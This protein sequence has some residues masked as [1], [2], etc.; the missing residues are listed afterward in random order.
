MTNCYGS[1]YQTI[2]N[3]QDFYMFCHNALS[4]MSECKITL[5]RIRCKQVKKHIFLYSRDVSLNVP[6]LYLIQISYCSLKKVFI[7]SFVNVTKSWSVSDRFF[8]PDVTT[9]INVKTRIQ[10]HWKMNLCSTCFCPQPLGR[11]SRT[12]WKEPVMT[13]CTDTSQNHK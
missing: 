4:S 8:L 12:L 6:T 13:N 2:S 9:Q 1:F 5:S 10:F 7:L 3:Q 11:S